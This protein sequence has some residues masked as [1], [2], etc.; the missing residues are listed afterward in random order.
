MENSMRQTQTRNLLGGRTGPNEFR[1]YHDLCCRL[2]R[3]SLLELDLPMRFRPLSTLFTRFGCF[4]ASDL[5]WRNA[6]GKKGAQ[7]KCA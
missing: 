3:C 2:H 6:T 7:I 4:V 1:R 5:S